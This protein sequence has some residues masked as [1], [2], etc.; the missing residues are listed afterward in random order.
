MSHESII[1]KEGWSSIAVC[2]ALTVIT[3]FSLQPVWSIV[4]L[5]LTAFCIY[6]FRNPKR[7]AVEGR[8]IIV[9]PADGKVM[10]ID[11]IVENSY[12]CNEAIRIRI[13]LNVFNV[14]INRMP[15][16][17]RV[18]WIEKTGGLN[19]PAFI[20]KAADKNVRNYVGLTT[21]WGKVM[22]VQITGLI[23][24]RI[25]CWVESGD[26]LN[27]G[28]RFGLIRFGSCTELY[29][30]SNAQVLVKPGQRIKGGETIV[31]KFSD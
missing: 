20:G 28:E 18:E 14:H 7:Q 24:R 22:V 13:F 30:P 26:S 3:F 25:V 31:G 11:K 8:G 15:V 21:D 6:F 17:A 4:P 23:A 12:L 2:L 10:S 5:I 1:V 9:A 19:L 29:L 27:I 16:S